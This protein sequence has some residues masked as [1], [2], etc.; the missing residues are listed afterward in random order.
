MPEI[1]SRKLK[2]DPLT[3]FG[4]PDKV[5]MALLAAM[6]HQRKHYVGYAFGFMD[7]LSLN[8]ECTSERLEQ[9][10]MYIDLSF[11]QFNG[12]QGPA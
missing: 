7:G 12:S 11:F 6:I 1:L 4:F 9:K 10:A 3:K 5:K 2:R 8:N